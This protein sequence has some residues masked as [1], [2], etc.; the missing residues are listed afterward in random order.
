M[1]T[2]FVTWDSYQTKH[3]ITG[4]TDGETVW[5]AQ[6]GI[7][8]ELWNEGR[9]LIRLALAENNLLTGRGSRFEHG[10]YAVV[11]E[12]VRGKTDG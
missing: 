12:A 8:E 5:G 2:I 7:P 3:Y 4:A 9:N 6:N 1:D 11:V 10:D